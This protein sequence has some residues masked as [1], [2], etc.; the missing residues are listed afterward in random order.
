[1]TRALDSGYAP[2]MCSFF[3]LFLWQLQRQTL[4]LM[5]D[6]DT[7][8][9]YF[10]SSMSSL[11]QPLRQVQSSPQESPHLLPP[12]AAFR[13]IQA[14]QSLPAAQAGQSTLKNFCSQLP[15]LTAFGSVLTR[16]IQPNRL[17]SLATHENGTIITYM[18]NCYPAICR[19]LLCCGVRPVSHSVL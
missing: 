6:A 12:L 10:I 5:V 11:S 3:L 13:C 16:V 17:Q 7:V 14:S 15:P 1:M 19:S 2:P 4:N 9:V 18:S 8:R